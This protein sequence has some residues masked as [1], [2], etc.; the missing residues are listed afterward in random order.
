MAGKATSWMLRN[1]VRLHLSETGEHI[2]IQPYFARGLDY[3]AGAIDTIYGEASLAWRKKSDRIYEVHIHL[4][5][6]MKCTFNDELSYQMLSS[7]MESSHLTGHIH[8]VY[9]FQ[10]MV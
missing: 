10:D 2:R 3:V 4:P 9:E 6:G 8:W 5:I 1:L 7:R